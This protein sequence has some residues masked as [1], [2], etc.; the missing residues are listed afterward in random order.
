MMFVSC[1][2]ADRE[3]ARRL[4][5][6]LADAL[7]PDIHFVT[8]IDVVSPGDNLLANITDTLSKADGLIAITSEASASSE[9]IRSE[10]AW[11]LAQ[12]D[13]KLPIYPVLIGSPD[14]IPYLLRAYVYID[15]RDS[16]KFKENVTILAKAIAQNI[17]VPRLY[18]ARRDVVDAEELF[19]DIQHDNLNAL[20]Q[21]EIIERR[22]EHTRLVL[23]I[24]ILFSLLSVIAIPLGLFVQSGDQL[25]E[26][27][28]IVLSPI[29][30][31]LGTIFGFYFGRNSVGGTDPH[32]SPASKQKSE[33]P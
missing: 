26:V 25:R 2:H 5:R 1:A 33:V 13:G 14:S 9:W 23:A 10:V 18:S 19:I 30:G 3:F 12:R 22:R 7:P 20:R 32:G 28:S 24:A 15:F 21:S 29:I 8:D 31:L 27:A 16:A 6:S 4:I 17:K 11:A